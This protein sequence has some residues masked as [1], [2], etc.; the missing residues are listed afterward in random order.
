MATDKNIPPEGGLRRFAL[1]LE[2]DGT[3]Y[4]GFQWQPGAPTI[5]SELEL[6]IEKATGEEVRVAGAGRTDSGVHAWG[7]VAAFLTTSALSPETMVQALNHHLPNDISVHKAAEV[8]PGFDPRRDALSRRYSYV[9]YNRP[10]PSPIL[11]R[12]SCHV[13]GNLNVDEMGRSAELLVGTHDFASF[14]KSP[15]KTGAS[16]VRRVTEASIHE[17]GVL[18]ILKIEGNAFL[19]HQV[20]RTAGALVE[21]GRGRLSVEEFAELIERPRPGV[22]GPNLSPQGLFLEEVRYPDPGP[23]PG[24]ESVEAGMSTL[25]IYD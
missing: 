12:H 25:A 2:Y 22:A 20:R 24:R 4:L 7:Q 9:I 3:R 13:R 16:T 18:I 17:D 10:T 5:Q 1:L 6:A 19:T 11:R 23:F 15:E 8:D 14:A 21:V